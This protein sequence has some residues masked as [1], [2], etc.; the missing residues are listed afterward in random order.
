MGSINKRF[1]KNVAANTADEFECIPSNGAV[2]HFY[3]FGGNAGLSPDTVC[4]IWWDKGGTD[5]ELLFV[6]HGDA[7]HSVSV[8]KTGDG[9][10]KITMR[11]VNDQ[12]NADTLGVFM[13]GDED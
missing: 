3:E 1:Y 13:K 9:S 5:E 8:K 7:I 10:K 6:T 12:G 11:L 4:E 2:V